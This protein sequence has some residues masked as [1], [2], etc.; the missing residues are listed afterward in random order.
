MYS[1]VAEWKYLRHRIQVQHVPKKQVS[2]ETGISRRTIN[3]ML[4]HEI[5]PG[6]SANR[7]ILGGRRYI[8]GHVLG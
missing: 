4:V 7:H 8:K 5:P 1:D 6:Q 3:K 2:R